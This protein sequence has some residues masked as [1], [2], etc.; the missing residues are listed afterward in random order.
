MDRS[1]LI[2]ELGISVNSYPPSMYIMIFKN[3]SPLLYGLCTKDMV[4]NQQSTKIAPFENAEI[5]D[6]MIEFNS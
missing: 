4:P 3:N 2:S 6:D 5:Y 1:A